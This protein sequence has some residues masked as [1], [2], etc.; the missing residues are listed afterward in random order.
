MTNTRTLY[1]RL[2][3]GLDRTPTAVEALNRIWGFMLLCGLWRGVGDARLED[4]LLRLHADTMAL[5]D[6]LVASVQ[7]GEPCDVQP[8]VDEKTR[9]H[10]QVLV[11]FA[12][13]AANAVQEPEPRM[14][15]ALWELQR[16][17]QMIVEHEAKAVAAMH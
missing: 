16:S 13:E 12:Q 6:A 7:G 8:R 15:A 1:T 3:P 11:Q 9:E 14:L 2:I 5:M 17:L 4:A 10:L